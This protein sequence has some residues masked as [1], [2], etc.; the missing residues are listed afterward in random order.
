M[1]CSREDNNPN[2]DQFMSGNYEQHSFDD[3]YGNGR[4]S[5]NQQMMDYD[6]YSGYQPRS[7]YGHSAEQNSSAAQSHLEYGKN[8]LTG[9]AQH[10]LASDVSQRLASDYGR[11]QGT[12]AYDQSM[13]YGVGRDQSS[14]SRRPP[15]GYE[16]RLTGDYLR[17][18]EVAGRQSSVTQ[19]QNFI[20]D[21]NQSRGAGVAQSPF[22]AD[23][24]G[25]A[26]S[27]VSK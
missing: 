21:R 6:G 12:S 25:S 23:R 16:Q 3:S 2:Q 24:T 20:A 19:G 22:A 5:L 11:H 4:P 17:E 1:W 15:S 18:Q 14:L 13:D 8:A 7:E 10:D 26:Y 27:S 9:A